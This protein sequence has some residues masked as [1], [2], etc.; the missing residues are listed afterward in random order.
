VNQRVRGTEAET[1]RKNRSAAAAR[2]LKR[3]AHIT[4]MRRRITRE[5][6]KPTRHSRHRRLVQAKRG[7]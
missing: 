1:L 4:T 5:K 7:A 6:E 2:G 3:K